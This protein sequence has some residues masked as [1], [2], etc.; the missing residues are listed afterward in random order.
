[1]NISVQGI[2]A[3]IIKRNEQDYSYEDWAMTSHLTQAWPKQYKE[4]FRARTNQ[5]RGGGAELKL[6]RMKNVRKLKVYGVCDC[7]TLKCNRIK[8]SCHSDSLRSRD[9]FEWKLKQVS[10]ST[11]AVFIHICFQRI[12]QIC[13]WI[14]SNVQETATPACSIEPNALMITTAFDYRCDCL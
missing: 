1:M 6:R 4:E 13:V 11:F 3:D 5:L 2:V 7:K 9:N 8:N 14:L 10:C 12:H